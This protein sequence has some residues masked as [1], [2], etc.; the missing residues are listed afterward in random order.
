MKTVGINIPEAK[1]AAALRVATGLAP[2]TSGV[3]F[4]PGRDR[5]LS[6]EKA[7]LRRQV[8][9]KVGKVNALTE[10]P[11][12]HIHSTLNKECGE[13]SIAEATTETLIKRIELLNEWIRKA[14]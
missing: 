11:Y 9:S 8:K 10:T 13:S 5:T 7:S 6:D 4:P 12:A 3:A 14:V 1:M 2:K